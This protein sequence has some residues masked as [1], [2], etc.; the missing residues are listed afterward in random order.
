M[1]EESRVSSEWPTISVFHWRFLQDCQTNDGLVGKEGWVQVDP[2]MLEVLWD[3]EGEVDNGTSTDSARCSQAIL[4]ILWCFVHRTRMFV[5]VGRESS[6]ILVPTVEDSW[7]ELSYSWSGISSRGS[8]IEDLETLSLWTEVW[9]L[10]G[11]QESQVY[12]HSVRAKHEAVKMA[13]VDQRL[14]ARNKLSP[15]Q[16]K[17]GCRCFELKES[18]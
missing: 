10:H 4:S 7:E 16:S 13:R 15:R 12:I 3:I 11:S 5:N 6:G 9:Y 1:S 2:S 18:S 14:W 8:C 17:C